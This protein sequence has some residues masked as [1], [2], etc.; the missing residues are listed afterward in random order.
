M[1]RSGQVTQK[2]SS[3]EDNLTKNCIDNVKDQPLFMRSSLCMY[4]RDNRCVH[5][6]T[7]RFTGQRRSLGD[8]KK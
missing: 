3:R 7:R 8:V 5:V 6:G 2:T 4:S 1:V